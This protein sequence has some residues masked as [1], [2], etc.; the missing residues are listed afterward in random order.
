MTAGSQATKRKP[1]R[2]SDEKHANKPF[3]MIVT[4]ESYQN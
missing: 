1:N 3:T 2:N 4:R